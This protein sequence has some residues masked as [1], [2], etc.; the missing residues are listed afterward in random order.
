M[1]L[2]GQVGKS[3]VASELT[4]DD[5]LQVGSGLGHGLGVARADRL[6]DSGAHGVAALDERRLLS[7]AG[8]GGVPRRDG[9]TIRCRRSYSSH[10]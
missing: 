10:Q 1:P 3:N 9:G 5:I 7:A 8:G 4:A 6:G 2:V